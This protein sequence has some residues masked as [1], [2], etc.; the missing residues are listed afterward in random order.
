MIRSAI[1][2]E[3]TAVDRC[4]EDLLMDKIRGGDLVCGG[5]P[6]PVMICVIELPKEIC[7][8]VNES[9]AK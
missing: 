1:G 4:E 9:I 3:E 8:K 5:D 7:G 6:V 2:C